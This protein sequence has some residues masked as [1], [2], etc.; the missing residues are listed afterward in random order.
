[1][2]TDQHLKRQLT[3]YFDW[4]EDHLGSDLRPPP[5]AAPR[6]HRRRNGRALIAVVGVGSVVALIAVTVSRESHNAATVVPVV[7]ASTVQDTSTTVLPIS[8]SGPATTWAPLNL[9]AGM[10][11]VDVSWGS[12]LPGFLAPLAAQRF[13]R[14]SADGTSQD[15]TLWLN[16]KKSDERALEVS[17]FEVHGI[18]I[19][20]AQSDLDGVPFVRGGWVEQNLWVDFTT[21]GLALPEVIELL[22][23]SSWRSDPSQGLEPDSITAG[24][25]LLFETVGAEP[26]PYTRFVVETE[27]GYVTVQVDSGVHVTPDATLE[28]IPGVGRLLTNLW[29]TFVLSNDGTLLQLSRSW[30]NG[31]VVGVVADAGLDVSRSMARVDEATVVALANAAS[32]REVSL[33]EVGRVTVGDNEIVLRGGTAELPEALCVVVSDVEGC[34][35]NHRFP[36]WLTR[37]SSSAPLPW[38]NEWLLAG[39]DWLFVTYGPNEAGNAIPRIC[40]ASA[41]GSIAEVLEYDQT[42]A[43]DRVWTLASIPDDTDFTMLCAWEDPSDPATP[44]KIDYLPPNNVHYIVRRP[45]T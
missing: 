10:R 12:E 26:R 27:S 44:N 4:L 40:P 1:M 13:A 34:T 35:L 8:P 18:P 3:D 7:P 21:I 43:S 22:N 25:S 37:S 38:T 23:A 15:A 33:P 42:V 17:N 39:E 36:N 6:G 24:L 29:E 41:D 16:V 14:L 32:A 45:P 9:P 20:A 30:P 28:E 31:G 11:V 5:A 19:S 2:S